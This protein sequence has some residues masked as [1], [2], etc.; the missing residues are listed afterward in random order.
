MKFSAVCI[1]SV[2]LLSGAEAAKK[3][4]EHVMASWVEE[5]LPEE[6]ELDDKVSSTVKAQ[7]AGDIEKIREGRAAAAKA[8]F[9]EA[10]K[11]GAPVDAP[12]DAPVNVAASKKN[13]VERLTA[14]FVAM[15]IASAVAATMV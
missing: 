9:E 6:Y 8:K 14:S 13:G 2:I 10:E 15:I 1:A 4:R 11:K 3:G 12:V 7:P 5:A